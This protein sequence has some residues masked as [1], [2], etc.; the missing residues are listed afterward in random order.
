MSKK[1]VELYLDAENGT[2][3]L[4]YDGQ[5]EEEMQEL[6]QDFVSGRL[7]WGFRIVE[8]EDDE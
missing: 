7:D 4:E 1:I 2:E 6:A 3:D 5:T 8:V